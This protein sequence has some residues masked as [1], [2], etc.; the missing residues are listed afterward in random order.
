M[1]ESILIVDNAPYAR[2][3][4]KAM[5]ETHGY[6]VVG[7]AEDTAQAVEMYK[8]LKPRV[9]TLDLF[10]TGEHGFN[11]LRAIK[12]VDSEARVIIISALSD[13]ETI[14][15]AYALGAKAYV[16]KTEDWPQLETALSQALK[17]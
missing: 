14:E 4:L 1:A 9:V 7:E 3:R 5:F 17:A 15:R 2:E 13:Q 12:K 16:T 11:A 10:L 6:S 8:K